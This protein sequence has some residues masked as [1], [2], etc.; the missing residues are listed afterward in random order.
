MVAARCPSAGSRRLR[1]PAR[2]TRVPVKRTSSSA[3]P[4]NS[5]LTRLVSSPISS[6]RVAGGGSPGAGRDGGPGG[7]ADGIDPRAALELVGVEDG[8]VLV[9]GADHVG[10][11]GAVGERVRAL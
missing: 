4:R 6:L 2:V 5:R 3:P 7:L 9:R 8:L 11:A 10:G 1:R